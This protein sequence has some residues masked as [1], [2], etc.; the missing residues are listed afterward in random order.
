MEIPYEVKPRPDTG[1]YN[2]KVAI[3]LF[4]AS[5]IMLFGGLFSAYVFLRLGA[6][7]GTWPNGM[8]KEGWGLLNTA[9]LILS[10]VTVVLAWANV[11][12]NNF[13]NFRIYLGI[14]LISAVA[15][16]GIK[17]TFEYI[18]KFNHHGVF[19]ED[20]QDPKGWAFQILGHQV[21]K[22]ETKDAE[23]IYF[24]PDSPEKQQ[25][26]WYSSQK[27]Y[28]TGKHGEAH[29]EEAHD[30]DEGHGHGHYDHPFD[31]FD[32]DVEGITKAG[33]Y[34]GHPLLK[35]KKDSIARVTKKYDSEG[36]VMPEKTE[37]VVPFVPRYNSY[38]AIYYTMT[39]LHALHV[40]GGLVVV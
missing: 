40:I 36:N 29:S 2:A 19:I 33:E 12:L 14:T 7:E 23:Y 25:W 26:N 18:P 32:F 9:I 17:L 20:K 1:L 21:K 35:I 38:F 22:D 4:L 27:L 5:E 39:G 31:N 24:A 6:G 13:K 37:Y 11:K 10:S 30:H 15:F 28:G 3:W 8:L 34:H 16:F